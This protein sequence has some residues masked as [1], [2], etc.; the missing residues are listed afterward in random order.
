MVESS[1][2]NRITADD[3][4][5]LVSERGSTPMQVGAVLLLD[6]RAGLDPAS[7]IE[8]LARRVVS[9]PRLRQRLQKTPFGCGRPV[10]VDDPAFEIANHVTSL[11][12]PE[13]RGELE[14]LGLAAKLI[15]SELS[16]SRPLWA[17]TLVTDTA[18]GE[19]ALILVFHHVLA[20]GIGGLAVLAN[21]VDGAPETVNTGFPL[22]DPSR[23][24]LA[25]DAARGRIRSL[26]RIPTAIRRIG[27][28]VAELRPAA[29]VS[30]A[31]TSLNRST[32]ARR[33]FARIRVDVN[34]IHDVAHAHRATVNDVVLTAVAGA[35][36]RL[37]ASRG[38]QADVIVISV[39]F[40]ARRQASAGDLGN[41]SGVIPL[42]IRGTGD[43][44]TRLEAVAALTRAAKLKPPGAST[45]LLGPLFRLLARMGLY[46]WFIARQKMIHT[47]ASTLRGPETQLSLL[48]CPIT[49]II[50]L[51]VPTGNITVS[52]VVL[53]YAGNLVVTIAAEPDTCPDL[54]TLRGFLAEEFE[55][56]E[57][58]AG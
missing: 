27:S 34:R 21:L 42:A 18:T 37:L 5:S 50:P 30:A 43:P 24:Q 14:V 32:G 40:S 54:P 22:P 35:L 57:A 45:L 8:L 25:V 33:S 10:W 1:P 13:P 16:R 26:R 47:F 23:G 48:S 56:L 46:E 15:G 3:L 53:S 17:A 36:H 39:P 11:P 55:S 9:V 12:C 7:V 29:R 51:S 44:A 19:A 38:E 41:Q 6:A 20:D 28:A 31:P 4:M 2:I 52:F 49:E 58:L